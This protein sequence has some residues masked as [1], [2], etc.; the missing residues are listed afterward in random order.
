MTTSVTLNV[1]I[2]G[3]AA[4]GYVMNAYGVY[5]VFHQLHSWL[6]HADRLQADAQRIR[7]GSTEHGQGQQPQGL[8]AVPLREG[9]DAAL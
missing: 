8:P 4:T 1:R 5:L 3:A 2:A 6:V 7:V 9:P